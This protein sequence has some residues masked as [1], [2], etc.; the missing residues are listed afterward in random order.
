MHTRFPS[1]VLDLV[2]VA[3]LEQNP[4]VG[5]RLNTVQIR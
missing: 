5:W 1:R 3:D 2:D 4:R